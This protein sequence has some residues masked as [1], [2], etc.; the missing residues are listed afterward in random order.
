MD[1]PSWQ[2]DLLKSNTEMFESIY[3]GVFT[4]GVLTLFRVKYLLG[5]DSMHNSSGGS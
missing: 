5:E 1:F 2:S 3:F 4:I